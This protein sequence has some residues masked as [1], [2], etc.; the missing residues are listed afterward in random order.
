ML[1]RKRHCQTKLQRLQKVRIWTS[2]SLVNRINP[3]QEILK[4]KQDFQKIKYSWQNSV[5][6]DRSILYSPFFVLTLVS[7]MV[8]LY[9]NDAFSNLMVS[10]KKQYSSFLKMVFVFQKICFKVK[11]WRIQ[12]LI[13]AHCEHEA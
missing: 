10:S 6:C 12:R 7:D 11:Q 9:G 8:V 3:L 13:W 4:L 1:T 5:L 2:G